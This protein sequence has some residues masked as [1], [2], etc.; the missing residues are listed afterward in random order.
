MI[1]ARTDYNPIQ[2]PREKGIAEDEPVFLLR[3]KDPFFTTM[4]AQYIALNEMRR[5]QREITT[6]LLGHIARAKKWRYQCSDPFKMLP[7]M[8]LDAEREE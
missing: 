3:A 8:P 1:H 7:D 5:G 6:S 4:L 2:D